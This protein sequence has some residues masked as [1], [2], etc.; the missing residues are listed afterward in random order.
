MLSL[1][2]FKPRRVW[3]LGIV[4]SCSIGP[5]DEPKKEGKKEIG[6]VKLHKTIKLEEVYG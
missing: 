3:S 6:Y 5:P 1:G 4:D 2:L